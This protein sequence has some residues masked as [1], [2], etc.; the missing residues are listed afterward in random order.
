MIAEYLRP[1]Y[2]AGAARSADEKDG[3]VM[4]Q[5]ERRP[6]WVDLA[7]DEADDWFVED[8]D[9]EEDRPVTAP[10][11][12]CP[13]SVRAATTARAPVRRTSRSRSSWIS[14]SRWRWR[15]DAIEATADYRGSPRRCARVV[16]AIAR[17]T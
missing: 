1:M 13:V 8:D 16:A 11:C 15:E 3:V 12:S 5:L 17:S 7:E 14:T 9:D 2:L 6:P 4:L 10:A